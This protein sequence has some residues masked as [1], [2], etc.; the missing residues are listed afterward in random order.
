MPEIIDGQ[1][2]ID[3]DILEEL[4]ALKHEEE[5][6]QVEGLYDSVS[7]MVRTAT[8]CHILCADSWL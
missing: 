6:L 5:R 3:P 7:D 1:S 4:D 2:F 8:L